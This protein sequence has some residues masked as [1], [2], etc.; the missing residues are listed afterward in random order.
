MITYL[1]WIHDPNHNDIH[2]QGYVGITNN[3]EA[4]LYSHT[5]HAH[6]PDVKQAIDNGAVMTIISE[7]TTREQALSEEH[8]YRPHRNIGLN[9]HK[10]GI[11]PGW[12][13]SW[14]RKEGFADAVSQGMKDWYQTPEG[15]AKRKMLSEKAKDRKWGP[16][17]W[18]AESRHKMSEA[19]KRIW[20]NPDHKARR[21]ANISA[22]LLGIKH[23]PQHVENNTKAQNV[24]MSCLT[25]RKETKIAALARF[26]GESKCD[27]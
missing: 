23:E 16:E 12:D 3:P 20:A 26:H 11:N 24:V 7:H 18:T 4:R 5:I 22:G 13:S 14:Q 21:S 6:N 2:T 27:K 9:R 8:R 10:G 15:K 25:C 1:Y 17:S 19:H